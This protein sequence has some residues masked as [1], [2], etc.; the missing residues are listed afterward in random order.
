[1]TP[2]TRRPWRDPEADRIRALVYR[3][4]SDGIGSGAILA[5]DAQALIDVAIKAELDDRGVCIVVNRWRQ[6]HADAAW[7]RTRTR[8]ARMAGERGRGDG[9]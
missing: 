1:M 7:N 9:G 6:E 8:C 5:A 3:L 2:P 4:L